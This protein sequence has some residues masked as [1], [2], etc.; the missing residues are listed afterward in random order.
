MSDET[1]TDE[2]KILD[3][4]FVIAMAGRSHISALTMEFPTKDEAKV[5]L[6]KVAKE[7]GGVWE[8]YSRVARVNGGKVKPLPI[9][10]A[11]CQCKVC[12]SMV[13]LHNQ[14]AHAVK[15]HAGKESYRYRKEEVAP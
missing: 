2:K 15:N 8:V 13:S 12:G 3:P 10:I 1:T 5:E 9:P 14:A 4:K 11:M 6:R 7:K